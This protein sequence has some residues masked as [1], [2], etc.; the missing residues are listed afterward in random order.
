[1]SSPK[2]FRLSAIDAR[3]IE[4]TVHALSGY[5]ERIVADGDQFRSLDRAIKALNRMPRSTAGLS[6]SLIWSLQQEDCYTAWTLE[7]DSGMLSLGVGG[8]VSGPHGSDTFSS[9]HYTLYVGHSGEGV[10][11]D[12]EHDY[13]KEGF[14]AWLSL[15]PMLEIEDHSHDCQ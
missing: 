2:R 7:F 3:L 14:P 8:H 13:W 5:R 12:D 1:M 6:L 11:S 15:R 4:T 9:Y 10:D